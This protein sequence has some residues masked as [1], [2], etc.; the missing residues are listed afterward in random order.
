MRRRWLRIVLLSIAVL[1]V[2]I[3]LVPVDRG[4]PPAQG[5][6]APQPVLAVLERAC[7]D[8]A[9]PDALAVVP[10]WPPSPGEL[11]RTSSTAARR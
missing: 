3:Q 7:Y 2:G 4:N 8:C 9:Q 6:S 1:V 10:T 11:P 5:S